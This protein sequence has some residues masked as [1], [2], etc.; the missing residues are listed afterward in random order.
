M[1]YCEI[2]NSPRKLVLFLQASFIGWLE[3]ISLEN[4]QIWILFLESGLVEGQTIWR[5]C[6]YFHQN[7]SAHVPGQPRDL[8]V[9]FS[10]FNNPSRWAQPIRQR[11]LREYAYSRASNGSRWRISKDNCSTSSF[12][13]KIT[14]VRQVFTEIVRYRPFLWRAIYFTLQGRPVHVQQ[15][16]QKLCTALQVQVYFTLLSAKGHRMMLYWDR[17]ADLCDC[18][19]VSIGHSLP[20]SRKR[21]HLMVQTSVEVNECFAAFPAQSWIWVS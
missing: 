10:Q 7:L 18:L 20:E 13:R 2:K 14:V 11:H 4:L 8:I 1:S 9:G 5:C 17:I 21:K 19:W 6:R 15:N 3:S 12:I 16:E